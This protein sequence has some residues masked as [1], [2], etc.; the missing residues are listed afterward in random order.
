MPTPNATETSTIEP[1]V[2]QAYIKNQ[3]RQLTESLTT[4]I[5]SMFDKLNQTM[6]YKFLN[7][8]E[9][10]NQ[11]KARM[12]LYDLTKEVTHDVQGPSTSSIGN[13]TSDIKEVLQQGIESIS[14]EVKAQSSRI[15]KLEDCRRFED[16]YASNLGI[17]RGEFRRLQGSAENFTK[18]Q[19]DALKG[20]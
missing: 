10:I 5:G 14:S 9:K 16:E 15:C 2:S 1:T 17:L 7:L 13:T 20:L 19:E 12:D 11:L 4:S 8:S 18:L 3:M 6:K